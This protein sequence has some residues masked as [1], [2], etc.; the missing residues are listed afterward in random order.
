M[1]LPILQIHY[2]SFR[3]EGEDGFAIVSDND[4][5]LLCVTDGCG[6]LGSKRYADLQNHTGAYI[7]ARLAARAF[8]EWVEQGFQWPETR[9]EEIRRCREA[10][11][12]L[13]QRLHQFASQYCAQENSRI[14]GS[15]QRTLPTTLCAVTARGNEACFW[16]AGD[17][18]GYLLDGEGL[19]QYTKDHARGNADAF[20]SLYLDA[21]LTNMLSA[22]K[23]GRIQCRRVRLKQPC[24]ALVAT[25]GVYNSL[26]TPME[27]EMLLLDTL[28]QA[29]SMVKWQMVLSRRI[30]ALAQD[31]A[32]LLLLQTG[33][34]GFEQ[35]KNQ[36]L[37][38]REW[39]KKQLITPV[40]RRKND[41][42]FA[43]EKWL[44]YKQT[45]DCT[46]ENE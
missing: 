16:W 24:L 3:D 46:E 23:V 19:R 35:L 41:W 32:T 31:D 11:H 30:A 4:E 5:T 36:L 10:E 14:T 44:E 17:S 7:A 13:Y 45:Y 26:A 12:L 42:H 29:T 18:R 43:R 38:R 37:G 15:M 1:E 34:T 33:D 8:S 20:E 27:L 21:P 28:K 2:Q 40:R 39:L 9:D 22:D 6:G 25:D